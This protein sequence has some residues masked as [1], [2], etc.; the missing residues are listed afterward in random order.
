LL[1]PRADARIEPTVSQPPSDAL[2]AHVGTVWRYAMRLARRADLAEELTQETMLRAWR[3]RRRLR[4]P[5]VARV[6][7]LRIAT[8]V[9]TDQM[10]RARH[11]PH[12]LPAEPACPRP[13]VQARS[14]HEEHVAMALAAMD[15]LPPRQRQVMHLVTC[16]GLSHAEV[17]DVL[18]IGAA[19][20]K[21]NLTL[22]RREM[23][24]RLK[25]I[26]EDV[27]GRAAREIP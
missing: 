21:S 5:G 1:Q 18:G 25:G 6:W 10:R 14:E 17:A 13:S 22:A 3:A 20:V 19:A 2:E 9:W 26:F 24:R 8:N 4:E 12:A 15:E 11:R 23:R 16:E 27:C 7:L